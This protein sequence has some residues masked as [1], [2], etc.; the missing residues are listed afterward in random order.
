MFYYIASLISFLYTQAPISRAGRE[1][2]IRIF[3]ENPLEF[4]V[5]MLSHQVKELG[6]L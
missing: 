6:F 2:I 3:I 4:R 1:M 5:A